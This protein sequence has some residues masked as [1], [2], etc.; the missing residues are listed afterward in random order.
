MKRRRA[1]RRRQRGNNALVLAGVGA[2]AILLAS[3]AMSWLLTPGAERRAGVGGPFTL[4]ADDGRVVT[5]RSFPGKYLAIYFGYTACQ[6][7]CPETLTTLTAAL[8][9]LGKAADRVQ[10]LFITVDPQRDSPAVLRRY[11]AAFSPGLVG[12]TGGAEELGRVDREYHVVSVSHRTPA[13]PA[14]Y[15]VDHSSVIIL[16]APDGSFA[17]PIPAD[18]SEMVMAQALLRYVMPAS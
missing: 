13:Q 6:D 14:S 4:T 8:V 5:E 2:A 7:V 1:A 16:L 18:A 11:V 12:L 9:H 3:A 15:A 17:A 10:P